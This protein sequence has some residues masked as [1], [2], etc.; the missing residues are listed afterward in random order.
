MEINKTVLKKVAGSFATG[1]TIINA[2]DNAGKLAGMTVSSFVS[3]SLD[4]PLVSF[5][6]DNN[7]KLLGQIKVGDTL[8]ISIL[9]A[10]QQSISNHFAGYPDPEKAVEFDKS[11][12]FPIIKNALG[13]YVT[14]VLE[15]NPTGDH[16][17]V[18]CAVEKLGRNE[19][20]SPLL[21]FSGKYL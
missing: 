14:E 12:G 1:V 4:P 9:A 21:Y 2:K 5:F 17:M 18:L 6:I 7:A 3:V 13:W 15:L 16:Y 11:E 8:S 10:N 19:D 20:I